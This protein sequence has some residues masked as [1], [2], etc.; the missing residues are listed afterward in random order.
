[1]LCALTFRDGD[2]SG[3]RPGDHLPDVGHRSR[4]GSSDVGVRGASA[5]RQDLGH[6]ER[7]HVRLCRHT[8]D[9]VRA[10]DE[11]HFEVQICTVLQHAWAEVDPLHKSDLAHARATEEF[12]IGTLQEDRGPKLRYRLGRLTQNGQP[13]YSD[14]ALHRGHAHLGAHHRSG[15]T[16][17]CS[18]HVAAAVD[19]D[20]RAG[21][22]RRIVR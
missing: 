14:R 20:G 17:G 12:E 13:K 3:G 6:A 11:F 19:V 1:M 15:G 8:P 2:R 5:G 9:P 7:R 10:D 18:V 4:R 21:Q 22:I 16:N